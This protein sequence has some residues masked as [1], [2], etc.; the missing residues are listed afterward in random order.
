MKHLNIMCRGTAVNMGQSEYYGN[1]FV[2]GWMNTNNS[3]GGQR[4]YRSKVRAYLRFLA[5]VIMGK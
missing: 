3:T 2:V 5:A 1:Q 4:V